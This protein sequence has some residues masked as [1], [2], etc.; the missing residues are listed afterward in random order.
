[1]NE[2][3]HAPKTEREKNVAAHARAKALRQKAAEARANSR[4]GKQLRGF[5]DF[6][7]TQGVV[8]MAIGLAI[9]A[10]AGATVKAIVEGFINPMVGFVVGSQESLLNAKW[11]VVGVDTLATDYWMTWGQRTLIIS[12]G[13]IFSSVITLLAVAAVIYFV[14]KG[15]NLDK[16][17][18]PKES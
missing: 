6:V 5:M 7:R 10:Q 11:N 3:K 16:L 12:W 17:D 13:M 15:F 8:G 2:S 18:K 1:M 14:V 4:F 9:G